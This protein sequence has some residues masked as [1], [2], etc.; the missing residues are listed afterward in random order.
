M[1]D[2]PIDEEV[3]DL[4]EFAEEQVNERIR[5]L[6]RDSR[7]VLLTKAD[8]RDFL[9][10]GLNEQGHVRIDGDVG[11]F[12]FYGNQSAQIEVEG[13]AGNGCGQWQQSGSI[14]IHGQAGSAFGCFCQG[15]WLAAY[16]NA[17]TRCAAGLKNGEVIVRGSVA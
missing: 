16:G 7:A 17:G 1:P 5:T 6:F 11:D 10:I 15:G 4:N 3:L 12:C 13:D 14:V 8:R 2:N 9:C